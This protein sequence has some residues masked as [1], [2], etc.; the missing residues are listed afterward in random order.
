MSLSDSRPSPARV[1]RMQPE[2]FGFQVELN[3][4]RRAFVEVVPW[5]LRVLGASA[6]AAHFDLADGT[7]LCCDI[8]SRLSPENRRT[9]KRA[10]ARTEEISLAKGIERHRLRLVARIPS[11]VYRVQERV[12]GEFSLERSDLQRRPEFYERRYLV[13]DVLKFRAAAVAV[14][15]FKSLCQN[16]L[17]ARSYADV[18][19][20]RLESWPALFSPDGRAY[21]SLRR[22]LMNLPDEV[23]G[24]LL[25][26]LRLVQLPRSITDPVELTTICTALDQKQQRWRHPEAWP[27]RINILLHATTSEIY[28]A[29]V[30]VAEHTDR[31]LDG[32]L[33]G[34]RALVRY[35]DFP[36]LHAGRLGGLVEKAIRWH[37]HIARRGLEELLEETDLPPALK[38][39]GTPTV[40][41]DFPIPE[42]PRVRFLDTVGSILKEG[43]DMGHCVASLAATAVRGDAYFFHI[44]FD[45]QKA[46]VELD[47]CGRIVEA[48]G[49]GNSDNEAVLWGCRTLAECAR[50]AL[51]DEP[52]AE[53]FALLRA[54][55]GG[56]R[57]L[58]IAEVL[59]ERAGEK[60]S[61]QTR[62]Y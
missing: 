50:A 8:L 13:A 52:S 48:A 23:P 10:W 61:D 12:H 24:F 7:G 30:R 19:L 45:R 5:S 39:L 1:I 22:T 38:R 9:T 51:E 25:T 6:E 58:E 53:T 56:S 60:G 43:R 47:R 11:V 46:T 29:V 41:P 18:A 55:F 49:P 21:G 62:E 36:D 3:S 14:S 34:V 15:C 33:D 31:R 4:R 57:W 42:D 54:R 27:N 26:A 32:M 17:Q 35:L 59:H 44:E 2:L 20:D 28:Q 37:G 40:S 16:D